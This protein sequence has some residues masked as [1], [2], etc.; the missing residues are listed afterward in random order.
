MQYS[1]PFET[2]EVQYFFNRSF[3]TISSFVL[4]EETII[5]TDSHIAALHGN[6]FDG[7]KKVI[8]IPAGEPRK[9]LEGLADITQQLL[10]AEV[11][12]KTFVLGVGGGVVTDVTGFIAS[13]YMRG[14]SFG[15]V[16]TSLLGMVDAA[17]GGKNGVNFGLQKNLLGTIN[18]PKF[19]FYDTSFL[20]T[21]PQ[22][23]WSNG[24]AEVIKYACLF[25]KALF[26]ELEQHDIAYYQSTANALQELIQRCVGWKNKTVMQ[27]ELENDVRKLLN[28]GHTSG[29]AIETVYEIPHGQA[30]ALGM[31]IACRLSEQETGLD[32]TVTQRLDTLL[33][34]YRLPAEKNIDVDNV[35]SVLKMDKKRT[36]DAISFILLQEIGKAVIKPLSI[37]TIEQALEKF[38]HAGNH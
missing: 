38:N 11:H 33:N 3:G 2:G 8:V 35:L 29:H 20:Q 23:E 30:V 19:I 7:F 26:D 9:T 34:K 21:L 15:F 12:R 24:F 18:Q 36:A 17:V 14:V 10:E 32:A 31:M 6:L 13:V 4:K 37:P 1:I 5:I 25:D 28:F 16:P 27:D 22:D